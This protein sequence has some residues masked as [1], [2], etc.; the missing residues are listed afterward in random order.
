MPQMTTASDWH[1]DRPLTNLSIALTQ[2]SEQF[3]ASKVGTRIPV[4]KESDT[5]TEYPQGF[6]N[7][8]YDSTR[9]EEGVANSVDYGTKQTPYSVGDKA[10]RIFISDRKRRN[11]DSQFNL[12]R[13]GMAI[14]TN[15]LL[16]GEELDFRDKFLTVGQWG[17]DLTGNTSPTDEGADTFLQWDNSSSDPIGDWK[18]FRRKFVLASAGKMPNEITMTLDVFDTLT[19]HPAILDRIK[20]TGVNS[21][22]TISRQAL[23]GLFEVAIINVVQTIVNTANDAVTDADGDVPVN[24]VFM[25]SKAFLATYTERSAALMM[26]T[27]IGNFFIP[28][29][30]GANLGPRFRTY[31][32]VEGKD[33]T[34]VEGQ[35]RVDRRIVAPDLGMLWLSVLG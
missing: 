23:A 17:L 7:R 18:L 32:A 14:V 10:L 26:A 20:T 4:V 15:S 2:S 11:A 27:A 35:L 28:G 30:T 16:I 8:E 31:R 29:L 1:V 6:W 19:E 34:Y 12:N 5:F 3:I 33:G 9:A 13:E 21:P 24:N 25:S 22:A